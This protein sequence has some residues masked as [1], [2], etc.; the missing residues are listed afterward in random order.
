MREIWIWWSPDRYVLTVEC[1]RLP[2][3]QSSISDFL[4][5]GEVRWRSCY[6]RLGACICLR[7]K[8]CGLRRT[9]LL[10]NRTKKL[11]PV[12]G[13]LIQVWT[14]QQVYQWIWNWWRCEESSCPWNL[15]EEMY[16]VIVWKVICYSVGPTLYVSSYEPEVTMGSNEHQDAN[17]MHKVRIFAVGGIRTWPTAML[18]TVN[19]MSWPC[20]WLTNTTAGITTGVSSLM[21]ILRDRN[22][23]GHCK[24]NHFSSQ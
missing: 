10:H 12:C 22:W 24:L 1:T 19:W 17:K 2:C 8:S 3:Q 18:S 16:Q 21:A 5:L 9:D 4:L 20:H 11:N 23:A 7:H 14:L 6:K 15:S 13:C